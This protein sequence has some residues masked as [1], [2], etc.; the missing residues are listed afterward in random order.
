MGLEV[1]ILLPKLLTPGQKR[2]I[3][4]LLGSL[5]SHREEDSTYW[6][7]TTSPIGG[8]Y[9][10]A[11]M[12]F[13]VDFDYLPAVS[14]TEQQVLRRVFGAATEQGICISAGSE[15]PASDRILGE[16]ALHLAE[17]Y[18]GNIAFCGAL[19]LPVPDQI[20]PR[21]GQT[22]IEAYCQNVIID[23]PGR[24]IA[25]RSLPGTMNHFSD[26]VFLRAWLSHP[27]F[28]MAR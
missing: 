14:Q 11:G 27:A 5:C 3:D 9:D 28:T 10:G 23:V 12:P 1:A 16:L 7:R 17:T 24:L 22:G 21:F 18:G 4:R 26:I 19:Q 8:S 20:R 13:L 15:M 6:F 25:V 2:G